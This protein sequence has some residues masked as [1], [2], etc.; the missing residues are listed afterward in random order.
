[1][2]EQSRIEPKTT[3]NRLIRKNTG[4]AKY[5]HINKRFCTTGKRSAERDLK[6]TVLT[7]AKLRKIEQEH[8]N[9]VSE[10]NEIDQS[11][12]GQQVSCLLFSMISLFVN[13]VRSPVSL[14][15]QAR[16]CFFLFICTPYNSSQLV[17]LLKGKTLVNFEVHCFRRG[18][19][20]SKLY[21]LKARKS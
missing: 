20:R 9:V 3:R 15:V 17:K 1:M 13:I 19:I 12:K 5:I 11:I 2:Q 8:D 16:L 6:T 14:I 7:E 10:L 18:R 21:Q 4:S